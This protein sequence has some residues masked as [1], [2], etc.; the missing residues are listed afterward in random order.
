MAHPNEDLLRQGYE[1][2]SSGDL[3]TV[4]GLLHDDIVWH[5]GGSNQLTGDYHGHE[6]IFEHFGKLMELS[7]GTFRVEAHDFLANDTRGVV[8]VTLH[9]ERDGHAI[10]IRAADIWQ[11]ADGKATERWTFA[12]D[13]QAFDEFYR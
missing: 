5:A 13:Q 2:Y 8:L 1:A 12:E 4:Q 10:A 11:I 3:D 9:S 7:G 6:Q